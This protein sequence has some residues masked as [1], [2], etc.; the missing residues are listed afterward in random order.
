MDSLRVLSR[1]ILDLPCQRCYASFCRSPHPAPAK[2]LINPAN[3][4]FLSSAFAST[5]QKI[6]ATRVLPYP[7]HVVYEVISDVSNYSAF[8]PYCCKSL[9]TKTSKTAVDG[10]SYPEEAKLAIGF[11]TDVNDEFWSRVYCVPGECVEAVAGKTDTSLP[12]NS[13]EH[14]HARPTEQDP[15]RH[16]GILSHLLTRWTLRSFND[17]PPSASPISNSLALKKTEVN[18]VVEFEFANPVYGALGQAAAPQVAE[19]LI[20]AFETRVKFIVEGPG[21]VM[22]GHGSRK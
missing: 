21:S 8:V 2:K 20:K 10:K 14:H 16:Q 11:S 13:I 15:T 4:T 1:R 19:K 17:E 9:V 5:P 18:L 3:R 22:Q 7:R 12:K 6:T